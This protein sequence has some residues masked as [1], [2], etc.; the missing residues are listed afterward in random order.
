MFN[1][2]FYTVA[3]VMTTLASASFH[4]QAESSLAGNIGFTSNYIWRG[5]TQSND[6]AAIS[7]GIDFAHD[8][9]FYAGTWVSSIGGGNYENDIY[10]GY[11]FKAGGFALDAGYIMY[12]YPVGAVNADFDEVYLNAGIQNFGLGMAFTIDSEAGGQ[13]DNLY[14]YASADLPLTESLNLKIL[15]GLYDYDAADSVAA[16]DYRHFHVSLSKD[17]FVF[18]LDKNDADLAPGRDDFRFSVSYSKTFDLLE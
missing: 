1:K 5:V 17:D 16:E 12:R 18:A 15:A 11:N 13:D 9:G 4:A 2:S 8:S 10:A 14:L 3:I 7:G 6:D